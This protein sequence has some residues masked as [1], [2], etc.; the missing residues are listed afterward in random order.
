LREPPDARL[1][2][3]RDPSQG[4]TSGSALRRFLDRAVFVLELS[5]LAVLF[6]VALLQP[7]AGRFGVPVWALV[8][9]FAAYLV[10]FELLR[11][12]WR[13]LR[14]YRLKYALALPISALVY[15][16]A[17]EPGGPLFVLFFV[18]VACAS[19]TL[20]PR[21]S[22]FYAGAAV[23]LA[24][25]IEPTLPGWEAG[26]DLRGLVGRL[27]L[28]PLFVANAAI[29]RRRLTLEQEAFRKVQEESGRLEELDRLR[30]NF[31]ASVS[32]GL[33]TPLT[34][35][36]AGLGLLE[37]SAADRLSP[38]ERGLLGNARR[39]TARLGLAVDDLLAYNQ[40]E[41]GTLKLERE[42]LDLRAAVADAISTVHP[43][44]V[45]GGQSLE[46][47]LPRPLPVE[48]DPRRLAQVLVNLLE[49]A[50]LHTPEGTRIEVSGRT[51][52]D[53]VLLAVSDTGP[54]IPVGELESVFERFRR[55]EPGRG[56]GSGIGL[57]ISR[58]IVELHGGEL[59]AE[60]PPGGGATFRMTLPLGREDDREGG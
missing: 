34:A 40:L 28:I 26:E 57:T 43:L 8:A 36:R 41:A 23:V 22:L 4:D 52:G 19:A 31:V 10:L 2:S 49:N 33:R 20:A 45:E 17:A 9:G 55:L 13:R 11:N 44:I 6:L 37:S 56:N 47:D 38:E 1:F 7:Q 15:S 60:S 46:M 5:S 59:R 35:A 21:E 16:L 32:H 58:G 30:A 48:G 27:V 42:P 24:A 54:G 29:L 25:A 53:E 50:H 18:A 3:G 51:S 39:N 14:S 12:R